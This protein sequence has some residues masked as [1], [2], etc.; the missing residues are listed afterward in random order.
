MDFL[1]VFSTGKCTWRVSFS[2]EGT[3]RWTWA[4]SIEYA[5]GQLLFA[6]KRVLD[7]GPLPSKP[8]AVPQGCAYGFEQRSPTPSSAPAAVLLTPFRHHQRFHGGGSGGSERAFCWS[9]NH[10]PV[11]TPGASVL[12]RALLGGGEGA[13]TPCC[14]SKYLF[15]CSHTALKVFAVMLPEQLSSP[16]SSTLLP[17]TQKGSRLLKGNRISTTDPSQRGALFWRSG[18][19]GLEDALSDP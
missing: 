4:V 1:G 2:P 18:H 6:V 14:V 8:Q 11:L 9:R 19:L 15:I 12:A 3:E 7:L 17:V 5:P 10:S 13:S 16:S